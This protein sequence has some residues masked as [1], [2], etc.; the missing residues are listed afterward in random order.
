MKSYCCEAK[1]AESC[2][3]YGGGGG[4]PTLA[5]SLSLNDMDVP[6]FKASS[7]V[8]S[9]IFGANHNKLALHFTQAKYVRTSYHNSYICCII[10]RFNI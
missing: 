3:E 4:R 8:P 7:E 1:L 2:S 5:K 6:R 9:K 10:K